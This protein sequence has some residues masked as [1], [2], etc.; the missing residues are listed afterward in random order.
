VAAPLAKLVVLVGLS[1]LAL[2][3]ALASSSAGMPWES[4]IEKIL[5]LIFHPWTFIIAIFFVLFVVGRMFFG[6]EF[7][8]LTRIVTRLTL[9]IIFVV[10]SVGLLTMVF[11]P[12]R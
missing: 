4:P 11:D 2:E 8:D 10:V 6:G 3:P 9:I 1:I 7:G 12:F 5:R